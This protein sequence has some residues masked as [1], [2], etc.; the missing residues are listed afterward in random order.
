MNKKKLLMVFFVSI[1]FI[2]GMSTVVAAKMPSAMPS[3]TVLATL[4]DGGYGSTI[5]PDGALYVTEPAAG[6]ISRIDPQTGAV[7]TFASGL[8]ITGI[9]FGG[10][11]DVAFKGSTAYA[12][13]TLVGPDVGGSDIVGIYELTRRGGFVVFADIGDYSINNPPTIPFDYVVPSGVQYALETYGDG[14]LVTDGHLNRVLRVSRRGD[15]SE[16]FAFG[17]VVPTGLALQRDKVIL[18]L[19]GPIPHPP[20]EGK[21]VSL[22][23]NSAT[24]T[25]LASGSPLLVDVEFDLGNRLYAL[26][27]G[28]FPA[29]GVPADPALPNT[30]ALVE[31][32]KDG[33]LPD[34]V[35]GLN[36]PTSMEFIRNTAYIVTFSGEILRIDNVSGPP[37]S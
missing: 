30:G 19:A 7:T 35:D 6:R 23:A 16:F 11:V 10:V 34:V 36:L 25:V 4:P 20:E 17:N 5:G 31:V 21:V 33:T 13:V 18:A 22:T 27:Q 32:R 24:A 29:G 26:S 9:P 3:V 15:V 8:P 37:P 14:F 2:L 1:V 28:D 12:L